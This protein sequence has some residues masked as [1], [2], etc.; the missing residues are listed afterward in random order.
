MIN[1]Q[2]SDYPGL[3]LDMV[4]EYP[5]APFNI[6]GNDPLYSLKNVPGT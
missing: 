4:L 5:Y 3:L 6:Y 2:L 1:D